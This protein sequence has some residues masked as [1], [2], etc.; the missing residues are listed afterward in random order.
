MLLQIVTL[1]LFF[2]LGNLLDNSP[3]KYWNR[4]NIIGGPGWGTVFP[5]YTNLAVIAITYSII[6]P[7]L[8]AFA[9]I[10]FGLIYIAYL[11]NLMFVSKPTDGRGIFYARAL[12]QT[13]TGLY[14]A[15]ICLLGLFILAKT[16]GPV[17]LQVIFLLFTVFVQLSL[18]KA[19]EPLQSKLPKNMLHEQSAV[20]N[21]SFAAATV[22]DPSA[23]LEKEHY[24]GES[25]DPASTE[26]ASTYR[27]AD[28]V[29]SGFNSNAST[30]TPKGGSIA[31]YFRPHLFLTPAIIRKEF[32]TA[33]I[34]NEQPPPL[35]QDVESTAYRNP[36]VNASNPRIWL[37]RDPWGLST[38]QV[39]Q[40]RSHDVDAVDN[41]S[42]FDI[43][44]EKKKYKFAFGTIDE[45]PI[46]DPPPKY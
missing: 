24:N 11:H 39:D 10:T 45:I 40:L 36:V 12:Y 5:I 44:N 38:K 35:P 14:L 8:L 7:L 33:P 23:S 17:V 3:R 25:P 18:Q 16:W 15:Q 34:F 1:I 27:T 31:R 37:P 30:E 26:D 4:R 6:A 13:F 46:W 22:R 41:G 2:V 29:E 28:R 9:A 19:F 32:L 43:D 20:D 21:S 42:W